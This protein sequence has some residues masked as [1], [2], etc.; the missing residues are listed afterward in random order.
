MKYYIL[1]FFIQLFC[2][3]IWLMEIV[4]EHGRI[5]DYVQKVF[6]LQQRH[7]LLLLPGIPK[8]GW[9]HG[10]AGSTGLK[11]VGESYTITETIK[12]G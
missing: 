5:L 10:L 2:F 6:Q 1:L 7:S 9:K 11:K 3:L 8:Y 4:L 12:K